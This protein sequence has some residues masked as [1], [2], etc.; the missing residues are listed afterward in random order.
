M[1]TKM[2]TIAKSLV[3]YYKEGK[4]DSSFVIVENNFELT[5]AMLNELR[6]KAKRYNRKS[7][8]I[9][10]IIPVSDSSFAPISWG[11]TPVKYKKGIITFEDRQGLFRIEF[12]DGSM[13]YFARFITGYGKGAMVEGLYASEKSVWYNFKKYLTEH[14]RKYAKPKI[15]LFNI[16]DMQGQLLYSKID[17]PSRIET[18]HPAID[19]IDQDIDFFFNNIDIFTQYGQ[20]GS[21]KVMLIGPPGT[22][23]TSMC[24]KLAR[25]L[26][27]TMSIAIATDLGAVAQHLSLCAKYKMPTLVIL[28][29]AE[30]TMG[31]LSQGGASSSVLNF[32]DGV[33]QPVNPKG[34]YVI[35]TTNHPE[36]IESRILKRPGRIDRIFQVGELHNK[37]ALQ[38]AKLYFGEYL[39][40]SK[41]VEKEL[42]KVVNG[43]TGAEIKELSN[44]SKAY[45]AQNNKTLDSA[46][47]LH[48]K[49]KLSKNLSDAYRFAEENSLFTAD[50]ET[51]GFF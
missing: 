7:F 49:E 2:D 8:C 41:K 12:N 18:I 1:A 45:A 23:K 30:A 15:G 24:I 47:I 42:G 44:S 32:L 27:K 37:Y 14:H 31:N 40:Y 22:G 38:C 50:N 17:K 35:M 19:S 36:R 34:S 4:E 21:R 9:K 10:D 16:Y 39:K 33:A 46:L 3:K 25:H 26:S 6:L 11:I 51:I 28:E 13:M 29:D 48:V 20:P 5:W 43:L